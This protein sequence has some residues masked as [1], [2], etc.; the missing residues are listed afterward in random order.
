MAKKRVRSFEVSKAHGGFKVRVEHHPKPRKE[1]KGAHAAF[2]DSYQPPEDHVHTS[3]ASLHKHMKELT[4]NMSV[5][6]EG[7]GESESPDSPAGQ[8]SALNE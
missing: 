1:G 6:P 5:S 3:H 2:H 4:S 7:D 8:S